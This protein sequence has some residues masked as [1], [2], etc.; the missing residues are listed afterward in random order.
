MPGMW[1][2]PLSQ[3]CVWSP[4]CVCVTVCVCVCVCILGSAAGREC[5]MPRRACAR[6]PSGCVCRCVN[7][8]TR[9][10]TSL[11]LHS[12][13]CT[14][15]ASLLAYAFKQ[16]LYV[17]L[18]SLSSCSAGG[19]IVIEPPL[20]KEAT[21]PLNHPFTAFVIYPCCSVLPFHFSGGLCR[22]RLRVHQHQPHPAPALR[23]IPA[24]LWGGPPYLGELCAKYAG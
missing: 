2:F 5:A 7:L 21:S 13:K 3:L 22:S 14:L 15:A 10:C 23:G 16:P 11:L 17:I 20:E 19:P 12:N 24:H 1:Q 18:N 6:A 9:L 8:C 4:H